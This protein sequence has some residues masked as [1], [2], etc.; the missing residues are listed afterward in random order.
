VISPEGARSMNAH[1]SLLPVVQGVE[2]A[3][4]PI[5]T[6]MVNSPLDIPVW[7]E[8]WPTLNIGNVWAQEGNAAFDAATPAQ[9]FADKLQA[10]V[11]AQLASPQT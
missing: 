4:D 10:S 5:L 8:R 2:P 6:E 11:D 1:I 7:Y 3:G 9:T